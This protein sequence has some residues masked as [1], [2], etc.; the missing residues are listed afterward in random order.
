MS[1]LVKTTERGWA[2]HFIC[3]YKCQFK[4]NTLLEY[5]DIKIVVSTVGE[6]LQDVNKRKY[7]T[8]GVGRN[9]ETM[10]FHSDPKDTKYND[11]DV[12]RRVSFDSE[13]QI[14]ELGKDNEANDMHENVVDEIRK[15]LISGDTYNH[16]FV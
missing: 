4:R 5:K 6:M 16:N 1:D 7:D 10:A 13:W 3:A 9:Y 8:R 15:G 12:S 2:G 11:A 14:K